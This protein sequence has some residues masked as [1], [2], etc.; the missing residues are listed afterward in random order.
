MAAAAKLGNP[1]KSVPICFCI[2]INI[3]GCCPT[4]LPW[5]FVSTACGSLDTHP[6]LWGQQ[7]MQWCQTIHIP[8]LKMMPNA[9]GGKATAMPKMRTLPSSWNNNTWKRHR[10]CNYPNIMNPH[11]LSKEQ[12]F[13]CQLSLKKRKF[14]ACNSAPRR[15][16]GGN[17][18]ITKLTTEQ[19]TNLGSQP[20]SV[21]NPTTN[22][23]WPKVQSKDPLMNT[24]MW[25]LNQWMRHV[26][27]A[28]HVA[29]A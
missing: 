17:S 25:F 27:I 4:S 10:P 7:C 5:M 24:R 26:W 19:K 21:L 2:F 9:N 6:C 11:S 23:E 22:L 1:N 15:R 14:P 28:Q 16:S 13:S 18:I 3:Y 20:K 12:Q 29:L 8:C